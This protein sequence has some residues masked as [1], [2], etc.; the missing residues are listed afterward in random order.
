MNAINFSGPFS[1]KIIG[2]DHQTNVDFKQVTCFLSESCATIALK[3]LL[4]YTHTHM[5]I[6]IHTYGGGK[7]CNVSSMC[8]FS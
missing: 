6:Y 3:F 8:L 4:D 5:Y 2:T 1:E 7:H